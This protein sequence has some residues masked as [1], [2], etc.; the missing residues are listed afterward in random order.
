[1]L[2]IL[3][4]SPCVSLGSNGPQ[5]F[6][7]ERVGKDSWLPRSHTWYVFLVYSLNMSVRQWRCCGA[8]SL[9]YFN[10]FLTK[11]HNGTPCRSYKHKFVLVVFLS[12]SNEVFCLFCLCVISIC[13]RVLHLVVG[14]CIIG[15]V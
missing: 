14:M 12:L 11:Y 1:M 3:S 9:F 4:F 15:H 6:C 7:I 5:K 10:R 8:F 2:N 13:N